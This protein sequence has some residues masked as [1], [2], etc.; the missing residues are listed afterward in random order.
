MPP[1]RPSS[2][3]SSSVS[4]SSLVKSS[5]RRREEEE[6]WAALNYHEHVRTRETLNT[7]GRRRATVRTEAVYR[8]CSRRANNSFVVPATLLRRLQRRHGFCSATLKPILE[9]VVDSLLPREIS[10]GETALISRHFSGNQRASRIFPRVPS[11][12]HEL[13]NRPSFIRGSLD[14]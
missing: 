9:I 6:E 14:L 2:F 10:R 5:G 11:R 1:P 12:W 4:F 3:S 7:V 13:L 8:V